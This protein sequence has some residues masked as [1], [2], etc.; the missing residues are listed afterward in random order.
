MASTARPFAESLKGLCILVV[1][2]DFL[3]LSELEALL[4]DGGADCILSCRSLGEATAMIEGRKPAVALLDV[5][6]GQE[7]VAPVAHRLA[8]SGIPFLFYTGQ[9]GGDRMLAEWRDRPLLSKPSS[10]RQI[11]SAVADLVH[12]EP[13][14]SRRSA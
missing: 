1:E 5:R 13:T 4:R 9:I 2:D 8:A 12:Q 3:V 10:S 11:V 14:P 6:I 7:S